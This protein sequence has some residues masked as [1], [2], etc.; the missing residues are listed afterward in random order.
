M[1]RDALA[2]LEGHNDD[3]EAVCN[4]VIYLRAEVEELKDKVHEQR[5]EIDS[6]ECE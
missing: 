6:H 3:I 1:T 5:A 2:V 4:E